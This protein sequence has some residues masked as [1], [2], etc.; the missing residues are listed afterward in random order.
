MDA[1]VAALERVD[2]FLG[3]L[4]DALPAD[5]LLVI[6]SDHGNVEDVTDRPHPKPRSRPR[7]R[8]RGR[9]D[10]AAPRATITDVAPDLLRLLDVRRR[11]LSIL[12]RPHRRSRAIRAVLYDFDG[13]L[14]DSTELI[15]RCYRHTMAAH[16]GEA[17]P[18]EE[19]LS[20]LRHPAGGRR[21]GRFA[22]SDAEQ[23]AMLETYMRFQRASTTRAA[24]ALSRARWRRCAAWRR[25][26]SPLAIVTSQHRESTLRGMELCG[27]VDHFPEIVTPE[28]V[29]HAK[30]HPEPVLAALSGWA[31]R[32]RRRSSWATRPT[33][34]RRGGPRGRA[35][36]RPSGG[37]FPARRWKPSGPTSSSRSRG[38]AGARG[39]RGRRRSARR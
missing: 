24:P 2:A 22:R 37:P 35:P 23:P 34:W 13:T 6:A 8:A 20:R 10:R 38:G 39:R 17:P 27:L 25:A 18:D 3:G 15:M 9:A 5:A 14:A 21:S 30:P 4:V 19:W 11:S 29:T 31:W 1:A 16:L 12:N 36:P 28:D 32:P 33:T 26:A 7:A